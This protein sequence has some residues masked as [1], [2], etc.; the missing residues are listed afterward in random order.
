MANKKE[1]LLSVSEA[2][3]ILGVVRQ[4]VLQLIYADRLDAEKVGRQY[5]IRESNLNA[6]KNRK[7]GRPKKNTKK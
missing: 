6:V 7:N 2:A 3:E 1:K 4:R 5:V